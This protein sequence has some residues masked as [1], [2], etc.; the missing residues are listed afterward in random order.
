MIS[1][2]AVLVAHASVVRADLLRFL[3]LVSWQRG[4]IDPGR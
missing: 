2:M 3:K 1:G 4:T